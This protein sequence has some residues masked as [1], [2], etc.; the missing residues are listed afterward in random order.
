MDCNQ[1]LIRAIAVTVAIAVLSLVPTTSKAE[2]MTGEELKKLYANGVTECGEY[3]KGG[4]LIPYCEY[5]RTD[6]TIIGK[7]YTG[8]YHIKAEEGLVCYVTATAACGPYEHKSGDVYTVPFGDGSRGDVTIV[9]G[10]TEN[11]E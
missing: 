7:G 4:K 9:E 11:L 1:N 10:D 5:W 2:P 6:G 3:P 8:R